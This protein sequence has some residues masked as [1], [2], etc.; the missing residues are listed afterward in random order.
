MVLR[1][2]IQLRIQHRNPLGCKNRD[3]QPKL[4]GELYR[5]GKIVRLQYPRMPQTPNDCT[6]ETLQVEERAL[7]GQ[8]CLGVFHEVSFAKA[9]FAQDLRLHDTHGMRLVRLEMSAMPFSSCALRLKSLVFL[10]HGA[11]Q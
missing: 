2:V 7:R 5:S 10:V 11:H 4:R 1:Y 9:A 3:G 6:E 8:D